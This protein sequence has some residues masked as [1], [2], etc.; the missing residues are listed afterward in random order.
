MPSDDQSKR[1]F[2]YILT[3]ADIDLP[4]CKIG[5]TARD[6][7]RRV[8]E[9]NRSST[10][11]F[12]WE[13][14]HSIAVDDCRAFE[15]LVHAKLAPLRQ[16][17]REFFNIDEDAALRAVRSILEGQSLI[18]EID[19]RELADAARRPGAGRAV[20]RKRKPGK[21]RQV[22]FRASDRTYA[23]M[24]HAFTTVLRIQGRPFGQLNKP[25]FGV[26]DGRDGVQWNLAIHTDPVQARVGVN[27]EGMRYDG[28]P[29]ARLLLAERDQPQLPSIAAELG[30]AGRIHLSLRR[31]A[32]QVQSRPLIAEGHIGGGEF[33]LSE[34]DAS[35]WSSLVREALGCLNET[36][37][38]QGR[39][40][41]RVTLIGSDPNRVR[42]LPVTPHLTVWTDVPI[43][44]DCEADL[45]DALSLLQ[46][47]HEWVSGR[48]SI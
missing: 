41:Q 16:K 12:L 28:W 33:A 5:R 46:P 38:Y 30:D 11:D 44:A 39:A 21:A 17:R 37:G 45:R 9:I 48:I 32:W 23:A 47:I 34:L 7:D 36:K 14:A 35:K 3:V 10:G 22:E 2:L 19:A 29:I 26:S 27:L 4:V 43:G 42:E 6:P 15:A 40:K 31:D 24:L 8:A 25:S 1:G 13:V 20:R 18:S